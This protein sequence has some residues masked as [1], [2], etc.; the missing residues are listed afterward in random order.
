[1]IFLHEFFRSVYLTCFQGYQIQRITKLH[2]NFTGNHGH[3]VGVTR[4]LIRFSYDF[5]HDYFRDINVESKLERGG[6]QSMP[7]L[8]P[9]SRW[10]DGII[11]GG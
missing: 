3:Y 9:S 5:I 10:G 1:M 4:V 6:E 8:C 11:W 7:I 2:W